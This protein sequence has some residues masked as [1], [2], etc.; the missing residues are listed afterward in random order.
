MPALNVSLCFLATSYTQFATHATA[1]R[2]LRRDLGEVIFALLPLVVVVGALL[3]RHLWLALS[4][5]APEAVPEE[6]PPIVH[7]PMP[8]PPPVLGAHSRT[9]GYRSRS[10]SSL[11]I[12]SARRSESPPWFI[13]TTAP[14]TAHPRRR[15]V[16]VPPDHHSPPKVRRAL[17]TGVGWV[18]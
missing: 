1:A 12:C 15:R 11:H 3:V 13:R 7:Q 9:R 16:F 10:R 18:R 4:R 6:E 14:K 5:D 8:K 2:G 17:D